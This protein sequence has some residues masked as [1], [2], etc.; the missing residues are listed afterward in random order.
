MVY[1]PWTTVVFKTLNFQNYKFN[2]L[3]FYKPQIPHSNSYKLYII[4]KVWTRFFISA[5]VELFVDGKTGETAM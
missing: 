1:L 4:G 5:H 3:N 2:F